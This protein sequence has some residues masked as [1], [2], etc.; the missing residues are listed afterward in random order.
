MTYLDTQSFHTKGEQP[1]RS[2]SI[3][4]NHLNK[5]IFKLLITRELLKNCF[6]FNQIKQIINSIN[7]KDLMEKI[8]YLIEFFYSSYQIWVT[9]RIFEVDIIWQKEKRL[10][11]IWT[12]KN[13]IKTSHVYLSETPYQ[14]LFLAQ[15]VF[16][17]FLLNPGF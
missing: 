17:M 9:W 5:S 4:E 1:S 3:P 7:F 6:D 11:K 13:R 16:Q 14:I 15:A 10:F 8:V 2:Q 12:A